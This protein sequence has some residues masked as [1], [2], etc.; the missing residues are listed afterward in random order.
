MN[1]DIVQ[2]TFDSD[3]Y[4]IVDDFLLDDVVKELHEFAVNCKHIN[5]LY[6]DGKYYSINFTKDD[7]LFDLLPPIIES[8]QQTFS[9]L[10]DLEYDRGWAFICQN[11]GSGVPPH[12][13]PAVV[14]VNLWVTPDECVDDYTK[15]GLIVYDKTIPDGWTWEQY[16]CSTDLI[17][18][19]LKESEAKERLVPYRCNRMT[20]FQSHYFHRTNGVSM[21]PGKNNRRVNYTFMFKNK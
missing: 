7:H 14:N 19:Y 9:P 3:G 10:H 18:G 13:D 2:E 15:N 17:E 11:Q 21:K 8:I 4:V 20:L 5:D 16:N 1:S 6:P 12:A